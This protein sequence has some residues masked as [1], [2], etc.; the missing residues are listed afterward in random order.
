MSTRVK[1][2]VHPAARVTTVC[3]FCWEEIKKGSVLLLT[4]LALA[5]CHFGTFA[6]AEG[7]YLPAQ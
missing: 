5:P 4:L 6:G 7:R 2:T 3:L 1:H